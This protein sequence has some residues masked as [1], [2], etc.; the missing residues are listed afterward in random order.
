MATVTFFNGNIEVALPPNELSHGV[1]NPGQEYMNAAHDVLKAVR[2]Y[3]GEYGMLP[4]T[5]DVAYH[6]KD[7]LGS[8]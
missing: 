8:K 7:L 5:E 2:D 4:N 1:E 6:L 3:L